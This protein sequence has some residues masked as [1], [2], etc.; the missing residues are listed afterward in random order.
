[1]SDR[2]GAPAP[3]F[4]ADQ[5]AQIA[6]EHFGATGPVRLYPSERDQNARCSLPDGREILVKI[7]HSAES[8]AT[9]ALQHALLNHVHQVS[10]E[11]CVPG[12]V[13]SRSGTETVTIDDGAGNVNLVRALTWLAGTPLAEAEVTPAL[14]VSLGEKLG[15]LSKALQGFFHPAAWQPDFLWNLDNAATALAWRGDI[16]DPASRAVVEGLVAGA[17]AS[18]PERLAPLRQAV[19]YQDAN[20]YNVLVDNGQVSGLI[21]FGDVSFGRQ[22][23]E[24]AIALAY[25]A[26]DKDDPLA[27]M[28]LV[29]RGYTGVFPLEAAEVDVLFDLIMLRLAQSIC[30]SSHRSKDFADNAYL[31]ISQAPAQRLLAALSQLDHGPATARLRAAAG[32]PQV[33]AWDLAPGEWEPEAL[34][35][36]RKD[37]I[38]PS[39]SVAYSKPLTI[40]RGK[41]AWLYD[42]QGRGYLDMVNNVAHVG[43]CHPHVVA[44]LARQA[45]V[46]NTNARYLHKVLLDYADRI[47][48]T[49]PA[50]LSACIFTCTG[51]EANELAMRMARTATGRHDAVVLDMAYHGHTTGLIDISPYKFARKGGQGRKPFVHVAPLPD[52][53]RGLHRGEGEAIGRA[54]AGEVERVIAESGADP[55]FF[56]AESY[57]GVG[58]QVIPPEGFLRHSY[59]AVRKAGGLCIADEVQVGFG[60]AGTHMWAFGEQGV[61]PDIVTLGKPIGA[62][63]P[64]AAVVTT[65]EIAQAFA[66]GMEYFNTFGGNPVSCAV[67]M[68]VLDVI[69]Q[70]GLQENARS[71]GAYLLDGLRDLAQRHALIGDVRGRG[72]FIGAELVLDRATREPARTAAGEAVNRMRDRGILLSTDGPDENVIKIKPPMVFDRANADL[73]LSNFDAVLEAIGGGG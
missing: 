17:F 63:H 34:L 69:E 62:G 70:E 58:G 15:Q 5:I 67:G 35:A 23:N 7:S 52:P 12:V 32:L 51:S 46:L 11:V 16:A 36:R 18:L 41:G 3:Q 50:G 28:E 38:A 26:L 10:P 24:L 4:D 60:R 19:L 37:R 13:R 9:I 47:V 2:F 1:M 44:A 43:H 73:F 61:V 54:Y 65:P 40:V 72:L 53:Y 57:A 6:A 42:Y 21:D 20:D 29:T 39:L 71:V 66:N 8:E 49:M 33:P 22:I 48:A 64:M 30:I 14:L 56:I 68:A 45:A 59:E 55:A 27:T 31:T 25:A